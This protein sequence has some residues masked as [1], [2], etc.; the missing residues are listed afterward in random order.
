MAEWLSYS[1]TGTTRH[2][3][4]L[5][6]S[7]TTVCLGSLGQCILVTCDIHQSLWLVSVYGKLKRFSGRLLYQADHLSRVTTS[8]SCREKI[9]GF[10]NYLQTAP[11][12]AR[13]SKGGVFF[14]FFLVITKQCSRKKDI[15][16]IRNLEKQ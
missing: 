16:Y 8:N 12:T 9:S 10:R 11:Y 2:R 15:H 6:K 13:Y 5:N 7:V 14:F 1:N 4:T 3:M